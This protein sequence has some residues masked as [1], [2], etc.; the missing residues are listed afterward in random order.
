MRGCGHSIVTVS[1]SS[2]AGATT[3]VES[4]S[5][6]V[7]GAGTVRITGSPLVSVGPA[8]ASASKYGW[9]LPSRIGGSGPV[10]A[11]TRSSISW[12]AIAASTCSTVWMVVSP[13]PIAV[14]RSTASTSDNRAGT[15]GFPERSTRRNTIPCP[16]GAGRN[17]ASVRAPVC[18]PVPETAALFVM[19]RLVLGAIGPPYERLEIVHNPRQPV[20]GTLCPQELPVVARRVPRH[21]GARVD[22]PDHPSLH[23][24]AR[25]AP[26]RHMVGETGLAR[27]EDVVFDVG[28][29][30]DPRL[31][32][33]Q[34]AGPDATVVADPHGLLPHHPGADHRG[35]VDARLPGW[36]RIE[37]RND[38]QQ[39][40]VRIAHQHAAS[41]AFRG[42]LNEIRFAEHDGRARPLKILEIA[43]GGKKRQVVRTGPVQGRDARHGHV[44][45]A[46]QL[47][48]R[49]GRDVARAQ[50]R[51]GTGAG[52]AVP[53]ALRLLPVAHGLA[54]PIWVTSAARS[55]WR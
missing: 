45:R 14:R 25:P 50:A 23:R 44:R 33:D 28:A 31:T 53:A 51:G 43:S 6:T 30:R 2:R 20:Q 22:V 55:P 21:R 34:I 15:S 48:V 11:T 41:G 47:T 49:E 29:T 19:L 26:D 39:R 52:C 1:R 5:V 27:Q 42:L 4:P 7:N 37:H 35:T 9:K 16:A 38:R 8:C 54:R 3:Y 13:L 46:H 40:D 17:V 24:D 36:L 10:S 18:S 12:A 32:G